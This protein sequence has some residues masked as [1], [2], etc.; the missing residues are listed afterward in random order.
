MVES[1]SESIETSIAEEA[2]CNTSPCERD[3]IE[4]VLPPS[5]PSVNEV[6]VIRTIV[7]EGARPTAGSV[8]QVARGRVGS[9]RAF[10]PGEPLQG[11]YNLWS[12]ESGGGLLD[13][14]NRPGYI[15]EDTVLEDVAEATARRLGYSGGRYDPHPQLDYRSPHFNQSHFDEIWHPTSDS[16]ATRAGASMTPVTSNGLE[17]W[18]TPPHNNP[19]GT[20]QMSREIPRIGLSGGLMGQFAKV[21]GVLTIVVSAEIENDY[22]RTVG[23]TSGAVEFIGGSSYLLGAADLGGGYFGVNGA[24]RLMTFGSGAT[25]LGG[26]V[27]M[28]VLSGYSGV[29]H[30]QQGEYGV[31]LGDGA[32]VRLGTMVLRGS[33]TGPAVAV[34]GTALVANYTGDYVESVVTPEY[35]R[36]WGIAAGTGAGLGIGA[37]VGGGLVAFG[38]VSNPVGWGILAVGGIAGFI[39]AVW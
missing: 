39:G 10:T 29:V 35:G 5:D 7:Q 2:E 15:M 13:A 22:V 16:L 3:P 11:P 23:M 18:R 14:A 9:P 17:P 30:F 12:N 36:G 20:V 6:E 38:L 31:L 24:T 26:G 28:I 21:S 25:R 32:G 8:T 4:S 34:T 27:G 1:Q 19:S 33:A 37:V